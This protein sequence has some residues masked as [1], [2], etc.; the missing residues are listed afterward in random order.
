[1][2]R[3]ILSRGPLR[4]ALNGCLGRGV[5]RRPSISNLFKRK[6]VYLVS[7][8]KTRDLIL[9]PWFISPR[10]QISVTN[11]MEL[12][13]CT[14]HFDRSSPSS[15]KGFW[16][17]KK[18]LKTSNSEVVRLKPWYQDPVQHKH[19]YLFRSRSINQ[20]CL[21]YLGPWMIDPNQLWIR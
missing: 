10:V 5:P 19:I 9:D 18:I 8:F 14:T 2:Q 17:K 13:R 7:L 21:Q 4:G 15:F 6:I 16:S 20:N 11:I 3:S 12:D 1:M